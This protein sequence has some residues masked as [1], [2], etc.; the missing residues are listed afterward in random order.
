MQIR[1]LKTSE[2]QN[3]PIYVRQFGNTFEYIAIIKHQ[4]YT[5]NIEVI[6]T[7]W[8]RLLGKDYTPKQL[9]DA[10]SYVLKMAE[11]TVDMVLGTK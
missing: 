4:V 6:R 10:T 11:T 5:A 7:I 2:Y 3:C 1:T 9:A 8:Q